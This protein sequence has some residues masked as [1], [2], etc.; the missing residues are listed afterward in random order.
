MSEQ[1]L[2]L[3]GLEEKYLQ[4]E[5]LTWLSV[6]SAKYRIARSAKE[7]Q[8]RNVKIYEEYLSGKKTPELSRAYGLSIQTLR[9]LIRNQYLSSFPDDEW[10]PKP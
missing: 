10:K 3:R 8:A 5:I 9:L 6:R 2:I 7:I 1:G 4:N